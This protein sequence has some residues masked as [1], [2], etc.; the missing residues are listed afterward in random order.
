MYRLFV[1]IDLPEE[2]KERVAGLDD[3]LPGGR[4]VPREQLHL[5]LRFIGE[6]DEE[7]F[8]GIRGALAGVRGAPFSM[9]LAGVGH[10]PPGR[11]PRVLWVGLEGFEPL[12]DLQQQVES[13]LETSGIAPEERR[14]S[15]HITIARLK[16]T[17]AAAVAAFEERH[18][19]FRAGPFPVAEFHLY[20][21][22]LT[23]AGA[24]HTREASYPL[25]GDSGR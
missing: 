21:S 10:F 16:E 7:T 20:S 1:A 19:A 4:R 8:A 22:S 15:P 2:V 24:I 25:A 12:L 5:T 9:T 11:H 6:V 14:F 23:R 18:A 17:P 3:S 13:A